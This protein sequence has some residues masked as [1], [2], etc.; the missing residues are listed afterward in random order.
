MINSSVAGKQ[1]LTVREPLGVAAMICPWNFP[2]GMPARK[3]SAA[4][5]AGCTAVCKPAEDTPL[6]TLALAAVIQM[7]GIPPA[8]STSSP[9]V[10]TRKESS[11]QLRGADIAGASFLVS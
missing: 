5:A 2:I 4:L 6:S 11:L 7:A 10:G 9:A 1:F 8:S 3:I